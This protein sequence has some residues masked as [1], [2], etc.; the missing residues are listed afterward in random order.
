MN[1]IAGAI[2]LMTGTVGLFLFATS[3]RIM[4]NLGSMLL[5]LLC[6]AQVGVGGSLVIHGDDTA[7]VVLRGA[8]APADEE[9]AEPDSKGPSA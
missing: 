6:V 8:L 7:L 2:V 1:R 9:T 5:F 4:D 3:L